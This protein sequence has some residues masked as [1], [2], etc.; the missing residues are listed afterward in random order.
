MLLRTNE[1][2]AGEIM[3]RINDRIK[4]FL[5]ILILKLMIF[6]AEEAKFYA[7]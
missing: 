6:N 1:N 2:L 5:M 4:M 7:V 3:N